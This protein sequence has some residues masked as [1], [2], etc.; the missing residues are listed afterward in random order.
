MAQQSDSAGTPSRG[1]KLRRRWRGGGA[2]A[3]AGGGGGGSRNRTAIATGTA[4]A[5]GR[6]ATR[7]APRAPVVAAGAEAAAGRRQRRRVRST[8]RAR[9]RVP[10][11]ASD[12]RSGKG[13]GNR[14][15][16]GSGSAS[17]P[18]RRPA[19]HGGRGRATPGTRA[20]RDAP[21]PRRAAGLPGGGR[22]QPPPGHQV[23]RLD[24]GH[25]RLLL[26]A[27]LLVAV[28][29]IAGVAAFVVVGGACMYAA[30]RL[31]PAVALRRIG[32]VPIDEHD[33]P[34]LYNVTEG[35]APPSA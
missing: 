21:E 31:A 12:P 29:P 27:L 28:S 34:R 26:G 9:A 5:A 19:A 15:R 14:S 22:G 2:G 4:A 35:R 3:G 7:P 33:D 16:S 30:W 20:A 32:A 11:A 8:G 6:P 13:G 18:P 17:R 25:S 24:G 10:E 1:G 23:V